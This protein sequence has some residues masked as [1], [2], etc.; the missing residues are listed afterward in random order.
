MTTD[1]LVFA[2]EGEFYNFSTFKSEW[3]KKN[4]NKS[5]FL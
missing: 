1:A 5:M 4:P 2:L 3:E